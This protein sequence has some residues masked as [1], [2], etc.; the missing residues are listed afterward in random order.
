MKNPAKVKVEGR[1]SPGLDLNAR[2]RE[3]RR[4]LTEKGV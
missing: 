2:R 1:V 3:K 4:D